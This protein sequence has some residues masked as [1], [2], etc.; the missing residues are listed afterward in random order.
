[1]AVNVPRFSSSKSR[2]SGHFW[3]GEPGG[4]RTRDP[5]IKSQKF[6]HSFEFLFFRLV[7]GKRIN[8]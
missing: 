5:M 1:M 8:P 4:T 7:S 3:L 6:K 2:K